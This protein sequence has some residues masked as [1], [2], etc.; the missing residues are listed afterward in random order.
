LCS[1][2]GKHEKDSDADDIDW[3]LYDPIEDDEVATSD[4]DSNY[5]P[6]DSES[7]SDAECAV[8]GEEAREAL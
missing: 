5:S 4:R 3:A 1:D 7:D 8:T 6:S 2:L